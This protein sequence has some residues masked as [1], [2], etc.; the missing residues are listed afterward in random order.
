MN[1]HGPLPRLASRI[2]RQEH[3]QMIVFAALI[4]VIVVG[5]G[6]LAVDVGFFVHERENVQ[7]AVDAG[8]LAGAALLPN[9]GVGAATA[10]Q[11]FTLLNDKGLNAGN[12]SVSFRCLV[13]NVATDV[14]ASCDPKTDASWTTTSTGLKA[15]PCVPANT[16][17][18]NVIVVSASNSVKFYLAP[19][20]HI[21]QGNT[22]SITSAACSGACGAPPTIPVDLVVIIDRTG[23]M[24]AADLTNAR[25]AADALLQSYNP[26]IQYVALGTL[27][28]SETSPSCSGANSPAAVLAASSGQYDETTVAKWIPVGLTG[29]GSPAAPV[30][31][32]YVNA[33]GTLNTNSTIVKGI[34]CLNT[35]GT[36]TNLATPMKMAKQYL[37]AHGRP[38]VKWGIVL[39]TDGTP[40]YG[41]GT[42][43]NYTCQQASTEATAAKA[44]GIEVFT[45]GFGLVATDTCPDASG[46]W[47]SKPA[48]NVL[49]DMATLSA[50][51][52][53]GCTTQAN[54]D[55]ENADGD[56]F[57]CQ[58]KTAQLTSIFQT[59]ASAASGSTRLISVP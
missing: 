27:G 40:N 45:I 16:D 7:Y 53:G 29:T 57:F 11:N 41:V 44:A 6:A 52:K 5:M 46:F 14:P 30:N 28:P 8:A 48:T 50:D 35:S 59:V 26:A 47:K 10:A 33:N 19:I 22:G 39:E 56:H 4:I 31:E 2:R 25:T 21:K 38:G 20:L 36:G 49:A 9:N 51:D 37:Q 58:P 23:S 55:A 3:G 54:A 32:A 24:S 12:V 34:A 18:C 42:A 15:S 13:G 17:K 1:R 43:S